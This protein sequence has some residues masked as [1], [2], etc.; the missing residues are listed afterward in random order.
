MK[1]LIYL[2][3]A[4]LVKPKT[5]IIQTVI[6][7]LC[8][9]WYN[10]SSIYEKGLESR[11]I[12]EHTRQLL[13]KEINCKEDEIIFCSSGSEA[14]TLAID[15]WLKA[16]NQTSFITDN[17]QHSSILKND[18]I[19][20]S[21][22]CDRD[23]FINPNNLYDIKNKLVSIGYG[24]GEIG[25][26]S[27]IKSISEI[28][29]HQG[30][31]LHIDAVQTFGHIP[32]NVKNLNIDMMSGTSQK[33]GGICGAAFLYVNKQVK[34]KS[35]IHGSQENGLRGSTYNVP[36]IAAFGKAIE[37]IDYGKEE[38]IRNKRNYLL[39][40]L[41]SILRVRLNGTSD[42]SKRLNNNI[43]ITINNI[44]LDSQQLISMLD[45]MGYQCSAT[46]ACNSGSSK[47][48]HVLKAIGLSDD[49]INRSLRITLSDDNTYK[50]L[51]CFYNDLAS[52]INQFSI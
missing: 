16:N 33:I 3:N 11:R 49:E 5:E 40:K 18:K 27:D 48:S 39:N 9:N 32:I 42:L 23:G 19:E 34:I 37:L 38:E 47:P 25:T 36:A 30:C 4:S 10:A 43:N 31:I 17:I 6:D 24:N 7:V 12:V 29:H 51:D 35:I 1:I 50:E 8:D 2:D 20:K 22:K 44:D 14:N 41:L 28:L 15:G 26:I 45:M 52:I 21:I 13:A 46:S